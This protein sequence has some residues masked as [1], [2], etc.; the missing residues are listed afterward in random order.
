M[1]DWIATAFSLIGAIYTAIGRPRYMPH[2]LTAYILGSIC[3]AAYAYNTDQI[4][5]LVL[6]IVFIVIEGYAIHRWAKVSK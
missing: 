4:S 1:I 5:L 2:A 3:W 6:N